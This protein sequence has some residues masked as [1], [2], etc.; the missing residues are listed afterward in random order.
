MFPEHNSSEGT[1]QSK[2]FSERQSLRGSARRLRSL[3]ANNRTKPVVPLTKAE[4]QRA[5]IW[6]EKYSPRIEQWGRMMAGRAGRL[7]EV[8]D[9]VQE[10]QL[11]VVEASR[12]YVPGRCA[13]NTWANWGARG[14][15]EHW[16]RDR[17]WVVRPPRKGANRWDYVPFPIT[18]TGHLEALVERRAAADGD[19]LQIGYVGG[20]HN[21]YLPELEFVADLQ[22]A[23]EQLSVPERM[24]VIEA[25]QHWPSVFKD[26]PK[27]DLL[28]SARAKLAV[29]LGY[30]RRN[31]NGN[32]QAHDV[33]NGSRESSG[34]GSVGAA[35][36]R[37]HR[38]GE[39]LGNPRRSSQPA[40]GHRE[41][42]ASAAEA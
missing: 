6:L 21:G 9:I 23:I 38:R 24:V 28:E 31:G 13:P 33:H 25:L 22:A 41:A 8:E 7:D 11:G 34:N 5:E 42:A 4:R 35:A 12:T 14:R 29:I 39:R 10:I 32:G 15:A 26:G 36:S 20:E 1:R 19:G 3:A 30:T 17:A 37:S 18:P 2:G 16:M 27:H 40:R